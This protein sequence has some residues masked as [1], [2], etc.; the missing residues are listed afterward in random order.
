MLIPFLKFVFKHT[1]IIYLALATL[2]LSA[3]LAKMYGLLA[4]AT[5]LVVIFAT[6]SMALAVC[7]FAALYS[8]IFHKD[9]WK[10]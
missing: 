9:K 3:Y 4:M 7:W 8:M 10:E 2:Y 1:D 5:T 6:F